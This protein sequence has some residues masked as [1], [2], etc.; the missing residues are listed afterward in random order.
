[1]NKIFK[2]V[3]F[4][5]MIILV[6]GCRSNDKIKGDN[7]VGNSEIKID[8]KELEK[9]SKDLEKVKLGCMSQTEPIIQSI[10]EGLEPMGYE[11]EVLMFDGSTLPATAVKDDEI[12]GMILNY[13]PWLK[14]FN[15]KNNCN[16]HMVEPYIYYGPTVLFSSK[17]K[18]IDELPNGATVAISNDPANLE[19]SLFKLRD[20][21]LIKLGEKKDTFYTPFDIVDNPKNLELIETE[22]T[23]TA[24]S[25]DD[26]DLVSCTADAI[27]KTGIDPTSYIW[28]P[29]ERLNEEVRQMLEA[30]NNGTEYVPIY[31]APDFGLIVADEN[32]DLPWVKDVIKVYQSEEFK[33]KFNDNYKGAYILY[34]DIK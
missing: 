6:V 12:D 15:E 10:K 31:V 14:V 23:L 3:L 28:P 24:R 8:N 30:K 13:L 5:V 25:I 1:M 27:R 11:V 16:L 9:S 22:V 20:A 29:K 33:A 32:K 2:L 34:D 26:V 18:S 21:N 7:I 19:K 17:Y 4:S